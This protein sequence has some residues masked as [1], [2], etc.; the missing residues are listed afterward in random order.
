MNKGHR[1]SRK[2]S[3]SA[4]NFDL[5]LE[6]HVGLDAVLM[7]KL[8][9]DIV[10]EKH[11]GL[12]LSSRAAQELR[13]WF[14]HPNTPLKSHAYVLLSNWFMTQSGDRHSMVASRCEQLWDALFPVRPVDR[15]S[16]PEPGRNHLVVRAEFDRFWDLI[17]EAQGGADHHIV[18]QQSEFNIQPRT[19]VPGPAPANTSAPDRLHAMFDANGLHFE[20][21]GSPHALADFLQLVSSWAAPL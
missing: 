17:I 10:R 8:L 6:T 14:E 12:T 1:W 2:L 19:P 21:D 4:N 3:G 11:R 20:V 7:N 16:S 15:L 9:D 5:L 18:E 13:R